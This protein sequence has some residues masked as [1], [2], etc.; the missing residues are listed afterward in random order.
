[1]KLTEMSI[2]MVVEHRTKNGDWVHGEIL[3]IPGDDESKAPRDV[4]SLVGI[5]C[6]DRIVFKEPGDV[7][8]S[9][10]ISYQKEKSNVETTEE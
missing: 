5:S 7:R 8:R 6:G 4:H 10:V 9:T 1:M 3:S 2:G